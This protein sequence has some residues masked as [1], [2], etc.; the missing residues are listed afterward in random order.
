[1]CG[2]TPSADIVAEQLNGLSPR[3]RGNL[4]RQARRSRPARSIPA[5]AGEPM[6][7]PARAP[8]GEVYPRVCGG[9]QMRYALALADRGLSPRVR[10]NRTGQLIDTAAAGS[11]PACA[12]EPPHSA[13]NCAPTSVYPRVCGGTLMRTA[14]WKSRSGLS[15]R[16]R[17]NRPAP[18]DGRCCKGSIPACAGEPPAHRAPGRKV[19]VYPRVCGGTVSTRA[20]RTRGMGLS[21]RV[22]GNQEGSAYRP[23]EA[24][25]IPACAGE[26][27][28]G[29][30]GEQVRQV[31]PR[32]CG[33][34]D[35]GTA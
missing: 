3:V 17:G 13:P 33:G 28:G 2:G 1:M 23:G 21:P 24:R 35:S 15:P 29:L 8:G 12:G 20:D 34:T 6:P 9:T 14:S 7:F 27:Q 32:V 11:I 16:V 30:P 25:S 5:C 31:Y 10:G 18:A 19:A 26:P 22:R 4:P